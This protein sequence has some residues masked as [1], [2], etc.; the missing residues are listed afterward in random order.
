VSSFR[1]KP[2]VLLVTPDFPPAF[3]GIQR[4]VY[5]LAEHLERVDVRVVTLDRTDAEEFDR[6]HGL[7]VARVSAPSRL[8]RVGVIAVL[9]AAVVAE[10]VRFRP[11]VVL[12]G[13]INMS[14]AALA[15]RR[16]LRV[17]YVQY[18]YG[19]EL[20]VRP[21]LTAA[22]LRGADAVLAIS[23]HTEQLAMAHGAEAARVHCI[24]PGVDLPAQWTAER[25]GSPTIV[26]I[27]RLEERY[28]GQDVLIRALPLVRSG[29]PG[30]RLMIV[31]EGPMQPVYESLARS[32]GL[33]GS[34]EFTGAL[35]DAERDGLLDRAHVFAMPSRLPLDG[36]GEGFGIV[37]L[38]A[39]GHGLPSVAGDVA[40]AVDA[41]VHGETGLLVDP[42][43]H[44]AVADALTQVL[45]SR[46]TAEKLGQAAAFRAQEF[47]WPKIARRVEDVL[48]SVAR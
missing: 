22:G 31:G 10:A 38:E 47:A 41:V 24:P 28:K 43:D 25:G 36:G 34:V 26:T 48:L 2:R 19:R 23:V 29:I 39:A 1:H 30:V 37:Y 45:A 3:G 13:H 17:P 6:T 15:I 46:E 32:L 4:L 18:L 11:Q 35:D 27:A 7:A 42:T 16:L 21:R 5:R 40:G 8:G 44:V 20:V 14:P 9:N 12:S 33:D